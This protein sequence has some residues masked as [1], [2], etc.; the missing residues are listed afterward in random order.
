MDYLME[1]GGLALGSRLKRLSERISSEVASIYEQQGINFEPRWFPVFHYIG[2]QHEAS[3][4]EIAKAIGV[5]HP[6]VNQIARELLS[7]GL[8][9]E[10]VDSDDKRKRLLS[11]TSKGRKLYADLAQTW[12]I[13]RISVG[14]A[15]EE[16]GHDLVAALEALENVLNK[17]ALASRF[18]QNDRLLHTAKI[19]VID[20]DPVYSDHFRRL[21]EAWIRKFFSIEPSDTE[22]LS[23]PKEIVLDGGNVFF[24]RIGDKIA[25]TCA[26][27]KV[28]KTTF[29]LAKMAVSDEFQGLGIGR[30][31]LYASIEWARKAKAKTVTLE[32]NTKLAT[33]VK[34]Y[35][36]AGFKTVPSNEVH[37]SKYARVDLIMKLDLL[38][39]STK[40]RR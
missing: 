23:A 14:E 10:V 28:D 13:I 11:L 4:V 19:E 33:A 5:T 17:K 8:I 25:G 22:I 9:D 36:K 12:R 15:V 30:K 3:I 26:L 18:N 2:C 1:L 21:N 31:L 38:A 39:A 27:V 37:P 20:F 32:T 7:I 16:S 35:K 6:A 24:A 34:L 40:A 29:E